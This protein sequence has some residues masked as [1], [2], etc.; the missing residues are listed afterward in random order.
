M[1]DHKVTVAITWVKIQLKTAPNNLSVLAIILQGRGISQKAIAIGNS[2][3]NHPKAFNP[4]E[5]TVGERQLFIQPWLSIHL[6]L[7]I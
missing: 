4:S 1:S 7:Y 5:G 3:S 2:Q 6:D